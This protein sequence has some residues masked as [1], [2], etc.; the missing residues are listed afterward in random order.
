MSPG[1]VT[2]MEDIKRHHV[3]YGKPAAFP[4][5]PTSRVRT[6]GQGH[7]LTGDERDGLN[8]RVAVLV[9]DRDN[10]VDPLAVAVIRKDGRKVGYVSEAKARTFAPIL[11]KLGTMKVT[12]TVDGSRLW[13]DLPKPADLRKAIKGAAEP[14]RLGT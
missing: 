2:V 3:D 14:S 5:L 1:N 11:D 8:M 12:C 4:D 10:P 9:R 13:L 6:V 7:Y